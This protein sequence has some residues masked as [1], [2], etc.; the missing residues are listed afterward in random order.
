MSHA[1]G[2]ISIRSARAE[3]L[4]ALAPLELQ[5]AARFA[6]S[7]HPYAQEL[8]PFDAGELRELQRAGTVWVAATADD[9]PVGFAIGGWLGEEPYLHEL[10]VAPAYARRGIGRALIVRVAAWANASGHTSLL[11]STFADVPWNAPYYARLG[12]E[13]IPL[14]AYTDVLLAQRARDAAAGMR[15]ESRVIMRA[16]L[17]R[18]LGR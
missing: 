18:L 6:D 1:P 9:R 15:V 12:F 13:T 16:A 10:D 17:S 11:L 14:T 7:L 3:D 5:A 8:P 4:P 2:L